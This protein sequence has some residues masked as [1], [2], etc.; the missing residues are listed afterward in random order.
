MHNEAKQI[1]ITDLMNC[2][3]DLQIGQLDGFYLYHSHYDK[4]KP[5]RLSLKITV[6]QT[7]LDKTFEG[8]NM[9]DIAYNAVCWLDD[10]K[11][12]PLMY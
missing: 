9:D 12:K 1:T 10:L 5:F 8:T 11:N 6:N 7:R 2:I 3:N 4:D